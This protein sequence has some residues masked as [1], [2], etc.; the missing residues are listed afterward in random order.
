MGGELSVDDRG[1]IDFM[2]YNPETAKTGASG[3]VGITRG[4]SHDNGGFNIDY[5]GNKVEVE[6]NETVMEQKDGGSINGDTALNI[7]GNMKIGDFAKDVTADV[8]KQTLKTIL[9]GKDLKN[10]KYKHVGNAIAKR[11]KTLN[12]AES[13]YIN[14]ADSADEDDFIA[15]NTAKAG[16]IG[17]DMQYKG[18]NNFQTGLVTVQNAKHDV[19]KQYGYSD[20]PKFLEDVKKG[21]VQQQVE[22]Q[23][24]Q[25]AAMGGKFTKAQDGTKKSKYDPEFETFIDQAMQLEQAN[26]SQSGD[27]RGGG[28]YYGTNKAAYNT[29]EKAKEYYFK[30]YWSKVKDLPPG[31]R[32][33]ALQLA[34]N[35]GDPYGELMVASGKM[36]VDT[37][38]DT[39]NQRKDKSIV[40]NKD[41]EK[42]KA[43]ILKEYNKDPQAFLAKL[44][45]EQNRY[46][47]SLVEANTDA[48]GKT[49][50]SIDPNTSRE[51]YDDYLGLA[52]F[53]AQ[54]FIKKPTLEQAIQ[55]SA[56]QSA[57]PIQ[58]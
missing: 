42:N 17:I 58:P 27:Y 28:D 9:K 2:G 54:P 55:Q 18:L 12:N 56:Q 39:K 15:L 34:I 44:D 23:P 53:A 43:S 25:Q 30:K 50:G 24:Y 38:R 57:V 31:L 48:A 1:D 19:A 4:P 5:N 52:N 29:P 32:T 51:F 3:Y 16:K 45:A 13:K 40:G 46:Y 49:F 36:S 6:G 41:W 14:I 33:R 8:D 10:M 22:E 7:L 21:K 11:T 37:R 26:S 47:D 20:T 35:T